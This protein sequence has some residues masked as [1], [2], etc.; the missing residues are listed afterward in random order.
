MLLALT[1]AAL[2]LPQPQL[3]PGV[4]RPLT[5]AQVCSIKWGTDRRHVTT[6]MRRQ[7]LAAYGVAWDDRGRYELDHLVPRELGGADDV[8]N[9]FPQ[10]WAAAHLKDRAE[11]A[12]HR[13]VCAG[14]LSLAVAQR[15]MA[16][17]WTVLYRRLVGP[18]PPF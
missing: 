3:T 9:L 1:L 2:T 12:A 15:Q 17:D 13:A 18:L 4:T 10:P 14:T 7:V 16:R 8:R 11:N 5:T 6:T